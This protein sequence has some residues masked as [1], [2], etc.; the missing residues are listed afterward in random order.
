[1]LILIGYLGSTNYLGTLL[2][3]LRI[4]KKKKKELAVTYV[5]TDPFFHVLLW[6]FVYV[7]IKIDKRQHM[8]LNF[9]FFDRSKIK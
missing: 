2:W 3:V 8:I 1:M 4:S 7:D 6:F 9:C 5:T